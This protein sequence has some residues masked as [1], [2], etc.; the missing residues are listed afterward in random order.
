[1]SWNKV[2][3][4]TSIKLIR[5]M[6]FDVSR[7]DFHDLSCRFESIHWHPKAHKHLSENILET[8]NKINDICAI[9]RKTFDECQSYDHDRR[10]SI[11]F[12]SL[13]AI[14]TKLRED[15]SFSE[16]NNDEIFD[17]LYKIILVKWL[18]VLLNTCQIVK[19]NRS[20]K[21]PLFPLDFQIIIYSINMA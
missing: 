12:R 3:I 7:C 14:M 11:C 19:T 8:Y 16:N 20:I 15:H 6:S 18:S 17:R 4:S 5:I 9:A 21:L 2:R 13:E 10:M 1:M